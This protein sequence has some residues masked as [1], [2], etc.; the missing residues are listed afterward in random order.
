MLSRLLQQLNAQITNDIFSY[1]IV[2]VD[3]DKDASARDVVDRHR[4]AAVVPIEY[5]VEPDQNIALARNRAVERAK[6]DY[7]AFIDDDEFPGANWLHVLH[8]TLK[9]YSVTGVLGSVLPHFD[10][11]PPRWIVQG[12]FYEKSFRRTG[13]VLTWEQTRTS[14]V[15][16]QNV[17]VDQESGA[18]FDP[19]Y[20]SGGEDRDLFRRLIEQGHTFIACN[21][22]PVYEF[23]PRERCGRIFFLRRALLRGQTATK[24]RVRTQ[25]IMKSL[26]AVP[27]YSLILPV[28]LFAGQ[29]R[30][31]KYA[32]KTA[33]HLGRLLGLARIN[34]VKEN[35]IMCTDIE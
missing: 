19:A 29:H 31:M 18:A 4:K 17:F 8:K 11:E 2:I 1:S 26:V 10:S 24:T 25:E 35:Y 7:I 16:M 6:G 20:G 22:A 33:E 13:V 21:E 34:L 27:V 23:I 5:D 32:E 3:N 15:L 28:M 14:N 30:V 9:K 12:H